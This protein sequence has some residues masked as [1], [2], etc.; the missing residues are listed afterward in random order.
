MPPMR[1]DTLLRMRATD[2]GL[3]RALPPQGSW[4][5]FTA[6]GNLATVWMAGDGA[7]HLVAAAPAAV[8]AEVGEVGGAVPWCEALPAGAA[9]GWSCS[10][11]K[12]LDALCRRIA[13][14]GHV[15][16]DQPLRRLELAVEA[17]LVA[18]GGER[19]TE[20]IAEVRQRVGQDL[21]R[22]ALMRYWGGRCAITGV[23]EPAL[24]RASHAKPWKDCTD[25][26]RLDV[27][28]GLLLAAHLDAAFDAGLIGVGPGGDIL[29]SGR[30]GEIERRVLGVGDPLLPLALRDG[31]RSYFEWHR[32]HVFDR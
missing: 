31:Q 16:P 18:D 2:A 17:A 27:H 13:V 8:A 29:V 21:F 3:D 26:E 14:L 30:L 15:L 23:A 7:T 20:R 1:D 11:D 4:L 24:L 6:A 22:D 28:N 9:A 25:A 19:T 10:G 5:V 32:T 12:A